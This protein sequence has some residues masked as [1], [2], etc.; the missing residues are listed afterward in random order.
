MN[1]ALKAFTVKPLG[2]CIVMSLE[3]TNCMPG[4]DRL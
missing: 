4:K 1:K 2:A 3:V